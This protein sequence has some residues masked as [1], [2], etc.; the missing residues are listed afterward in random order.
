[1]RINHPSPPPPRELS[2]LRN[3]LYRD[4]YT[5][6]PIVAVYYRVYTK[7]S[8]KSRAAGLI[9]GKTVTLILIARSH[10]LIASACSAREKAVRGRQMRNDGAVV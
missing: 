2:D 4:L 1:M 7:V 8:V 10:S 9:L 5:S 3:S 6:Y